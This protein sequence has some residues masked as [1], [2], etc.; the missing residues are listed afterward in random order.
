MSRILE[1]VC[2]PHGIWC[3]LKLRNFSARKKSY[4]LKIKTELIPEMGFIAFSNVPFKLRL[5][6]KKMNIHSFKKENELSF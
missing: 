3:S 6:T 2:D 5:K 1:G 4:R